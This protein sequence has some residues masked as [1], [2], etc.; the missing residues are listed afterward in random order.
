MF[1]SFCDLPRKVLGNPQDLRMKHLDQLITH[2]FEK[3]HVHQ[4]KVNGLS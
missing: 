3:L 4:I 2:L 1:L